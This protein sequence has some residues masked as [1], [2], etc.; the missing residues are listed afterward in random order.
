V[1]PAPAADR[2]PEPAEAGQVPADKAGDAEKAGSS[3]RPADE[4]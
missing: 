2:E 4:H 3:A 1:R